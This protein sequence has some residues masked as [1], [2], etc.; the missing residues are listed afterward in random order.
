MQERSRDDLIFELYYSYNLENLHYHYNTRLNNLFTVFQLLLSSAIIGNLSQ[1][2]EYAN[3]IIGIA[4][5]ILSALLL[6]YRF[7][8]KAAVSQIAKTRYS[9]LIHQYSQM[10]DDELR[11][12]L[13]NSDAIDN[14]ITG[15]FAD[16]AFKRA[17]IQLNLDDETKLD[18]YQRFIA[19]FCGEN[20]YDRTETINGKLSSEETNTTA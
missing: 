11:Q 17:S 13:F 12:A 5:A 4:L 1:Y 10:N 9:S 7:G 14:H 2:C 19:T 3:L 16:I 18:C 20:F 6:V 15:A 8:E